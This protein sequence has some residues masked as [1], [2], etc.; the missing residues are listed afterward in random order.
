MTQGI[1]QSLKEKEKKRKSIGKEYPLVTIPVTNWIKIG[2][3]V[4]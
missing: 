3:K 2:S 1:F 4:T